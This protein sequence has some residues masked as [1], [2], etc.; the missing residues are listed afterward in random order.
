MLKMSFPLQVGIDDRILSIA[1]VK[2]WTPCGV[3]TATID[4]C[5]RTILQIWW[6]EIP[7]AVPNK[8]M[9]IMAK[10][11][12]Q[13]CSRVWGGNAGSDYDVALRGVSS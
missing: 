12:C 5:A 8:L 3:C 9:A 10:R 11:T 4:N 7:M 6:N 2:T 13:A 1:R